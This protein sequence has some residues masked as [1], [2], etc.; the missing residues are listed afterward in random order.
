[1][2][3]PRQ[4][5]IDAIQLAG[6]AKSTGQD[7][8]GSVRRLAE[9]FGAAPHLLSESQLREYL[10]V[11]ENVKKLA[12]S[13]RI[14]EFCGIRF[15]YA[16]VALRQWPILGKY[17]VCGGRKTLPDV[18]SVAEVDRLIDAIR[19]PRLAAFFWTVY[20]L[21]LRLSEGLSLQV[22][23]IDHYRM[24]VHV[25]RGKGSKDRYVPLPLSTLTTLRQHWR[26]HRNPQWLF[27]ARHSHKATTPMGR[28]I[29]Q[30]AIRSVVDELQIRKR[31]TTHTLRHSYAT[32]LIE[33]GVNLRLV[34]RYLGHSSM[35]TTMIYLHLTNEGQQMA[36]A[37]IDGLM[38]R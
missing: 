5:M 7:Y 28:Q 32:H 21:G 19:K 18:L 36:R 29:V 3:E 22:G 26:T 33:V 14:R 4:R 23:D 8:V 34:Q 38:A 25:R 27:P 12:P 30:D 17:K 15:F 13:T 1:M 11:L 10:L 31:V 35:S 24:S 20:S 16:N 2:T 9:H 37:A 6:L